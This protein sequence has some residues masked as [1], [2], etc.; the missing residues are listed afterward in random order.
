MQRIAWTLPIIEGTESTIR[1]MTARLNGDDRAAFIRSRAAAGIAVE[2]VFIQSTPK[3]QVAVLVWDLIKPFDEVLGYMATSTDPFD[4]EFRGFIQEVHGIDVTDQSA[5]KPEITQILDWVDS[6]WTV[7]S[8]Q[9]W[10]MCVPLKDGGA[11]IFTTE[12]KK[13]YADTTQWTEWRRAC[14]F[15]VTTLCIQPTPMGD[16]LLVYLEGNDVPAAM[17]TLREGDHPFSQVWRDTAPKAYALDLT[18]A[19]NVPQVEQV[20]SIVAIESAIAR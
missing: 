7:G 11:D 16:M 6:E 17:Q 18:Q 19:A 2:R 5:P 4:A 14:G 9:E 10:G 12:V 1:N 8:G 3:G 15:G 13:L 20:L